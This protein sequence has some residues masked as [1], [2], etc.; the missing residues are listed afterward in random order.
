MGLEIEIKGPSSYESENVS[1]SVVFDSANPWSL[2]G[3][4]FMEFSGQEY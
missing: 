3:S 4:L 2:L 1:H